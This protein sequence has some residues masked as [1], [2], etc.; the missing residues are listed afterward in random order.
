[1]HLNSVTTKGLLVQGSNDFFYYLFF[2]FKKFR[3]LSAL[4]VHFLP[5]IPLG[6]AGSPNLPLIKRLSTSQKKAPMC[7]IYAFQKNKRATKK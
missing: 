4:G 6:E 1:M 2:F 3:K 7:C 5:G